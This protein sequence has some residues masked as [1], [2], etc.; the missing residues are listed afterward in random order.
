MI[1]P[2]IKS[3]LRPWFRRST[4]PTERWAQADAA[5]ADGDAQKAASIRRALAARRRIT[6]ED[7]LYAGLSE[8]RL[9]R[10]AKALETL[11][12]GLAKFPGVPALFDNYVRICSEGGHIARV[13]KREAV[14]KDDE[15][16][17]CLELFERFGD[18]HVQCSLIAY[19]LRQGIPDLAEQQIEGL[20]ERGADSVLLWQLADVL[21]L[22]ER[23]HEAM[24][25]YRQLSGRAADSALGVVHTALAA[26]RLG[27]LARA[28]DMFESGIQ[29]FPQAAELVDHYAL[30]CAQLGQLP[31]LIRV[32]APGAG[33]E[34]EAC[35]ALFERFADPQIS[36]ALIDHCLT[37][38]FDRLAEVQIDRIRN[39]SDNSLALWQVSELL[40]RLE[41]I[42]EANAIH[43]K[44]AER[45]AKDEEDFHL[46]SLAYVC[47][48]K[49]DECL[50]RLEEGLVTYP[51]AGRLLSLYMKICAKRFEYDRYR[52]FL[53]ALK[54]PNMPEPGS[55]LDF[56]RA[57]MSAPVD[58]VINLQDI[59]L[60]LAGAEF[61]VLQEDFVAY[62]RKFPQSIKIS[63]VLVFFCG[64]LHLPA[65]FGAGV[66]DALQANFPARGQEHQSLRILHQMTPPMI[67]AHPIDASE[68]VDAFTDAALR[69]S[70]DAVELTGPIA[71]MTNNWTPWQYIFCLVAPESYG[72]AISAFEQVAFRT[73][74]QLKQVAPHVADATRA[75]SAQRRLRVG[76][77][78]HDS[79]PMMSGFLPRLDSARFET[80]FLRPGKP[81]KSLAA[82]GWIERAGKTVQYSDS[83]MDAAIRTIAAEELDIIVSGPSI[84]AV[85]YP[86]MARLAP[87]QMVLLEPNWTDGLSHADYY[88]SWKPA[89][90]AQPSDYYR[91]KVS[92]FEHPP[93]WIE[94]PELREKGPIAP[95]ERAAT[96]KRLLNARPDAHIYLCA[97]T[98]P[99][100][101][102]DMDAMFLEILRRD[103][104]AIL[105]LLR[106]EYPPA[107]TLRSRLRHKLGPA[108][109]RVV[110]LTTMGKDDAHLLLQSVDCCIDS[111]PL[112]GMSSSFDGAMLGIPTVTL[113]SGIPFGNWTAAIYDYIGVEGLTAQSRDEYVDIALRLASDEA[114]RSRIGSEIREKS[115]RFV[116]SVASSDEFQSFLL[117]AW[118]RAASGAPPAHWM[119]GRWQ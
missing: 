84:A 69:L 47:L 57:S 16:R 109:E 78:V 71:D 99:K 13:I 110:F 59:E 92:Y 45:V 58:F 86:M 34:E 7:F 49:L 17:V 22:H 68:V 40:L 64:Y 85:Y 101:H 102:P 21:L 37:V 5:L 23:N 98:P 6:P 100:I 74:P 119:D 10:P 89:E 36:V 108:Y 35:K 12:T 38:G 20:L 87:L 44:L 48:S 54:S 75:R 80:V 41:R 11:E 82:K 113:P 79:M 118:D 107:K 26:F 46:S 73:W 51:A 70:V 3:W 2:K 19:C 18:Y 83:D 30:I 24:Q 81:G 106:G 27:Q 66:F 96:R 32:V 65:E 76:F 93:Y 60:R 72:R 117:Q 115:S 90:P 61:A 105:V 53:A 14:E 67:P 77:I 31:R 1:H 56:Y 42:E 9:N 25:I 43:R 91:T 97:N 33:S 114:W 52:D 15:R 29:R 39:H 62:L 111:Y 95:E 28:A 63:R 8:L 104:D 50:V 4:S 112:C 103:Q 94:K 116:E 55:M 88:I